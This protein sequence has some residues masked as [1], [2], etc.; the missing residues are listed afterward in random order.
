MKIDN[1][2]S[3]TFGANLCVFGKKIL[4]KKQ[5]TELANA[6]KTIGG[7]DDGIFIHCG[8][9]YKTQRN[10][11][12][13][14]IIAHTLTG[15][16]SVPRSVNVTSG[17]HDKNILKHPFEQIKAHIQLIKKTFEETHKQ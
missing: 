11:Y 17:I 7:D 8:R 9:L 16:P 12:R 1:I 6:V 3:Q 15:L 14:I 2:N 13:N 5:C 10:D 4:N